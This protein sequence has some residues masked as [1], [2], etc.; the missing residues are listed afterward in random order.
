MLNARVVDKNAIDFSDMHVK[1]RGPGNMKLPRTPYNLEQAALCATN[2]LSGLNGI[3][4]I[5]RVLWGVLEAYAN[6]LQMERGDGIP[7]GHVTEEQIAEAIVHFSGNMTGM[8]ECPIVAEGS[9]VPVSKLL[10]R[11][12]GVT[13]EVYENTDLGEKLAAIE[14]PTA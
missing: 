13:T 6:E 2:E 3:E 5:G 10:R 12:I 9:G 14:F 4:S 1:L 11:V 8:E 7:A